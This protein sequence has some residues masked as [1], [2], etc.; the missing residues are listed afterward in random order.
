MYVS[1]HVY[2]S[3]Y[4]CI[5]IFIHR[6]MCVHE[7]AYYPMHMAWLC[8]VGSIN[9]RFLLQNRLIK[10]NF[11]QKRPIF[12]LILLTVTTPYLYIYTYFQKR[13]ISYRR[14]HRSKEYY[15][16]IDFSRLMYMCIY[17]IH[18]R[19]LPVF[20][21]WVMWSVNMWHSGAPSFLL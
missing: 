14:C 18:K 4:L 20:R 3:T 6:C 11:P 12:F 7:S 1:I 21:K 2:I 8:I 5:Y 15:F 10:E 9:H 16:L 19:L 17:M 13:M